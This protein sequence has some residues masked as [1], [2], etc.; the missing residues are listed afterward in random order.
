[1]HLNIPTVLRFFIRQRKPAAPMMKKFRMD[2]PFEG[3]SWPVRLRSHRS[4]IEPSRSGLVGQFPNEDGRWRRLLNY[5]LNCIQ[6]VD[7][8]ILAVLDEVKALGMLENTIIVRTA[9][10]G[11]LA[12]GH[13]MHGKG[14]TAYREQN[15]VPMHIVHP[16]VKGGRSCQALT[17]HIDIVPT[18]LSMAGG[19]EIKKADLLATLKGKDFSKL[20]SNPLGAGVNE[21]REAILYNFNMLVYEDPDFTL[22]VVKILTRKGKEEG[23]KEIRRQGLQ[24]DFNKHRGAIRSVFDGRYKFNRYFSTLQNNQPLTFEELHAVNDVELFDHKNDPHEMVNL[25]ADKTKNK[26]RILEMNTKMNTI[27]REE[28]GVDDESSVGLKQDTDYAF[29]RVDI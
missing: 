16:D 22:G 3:H 20:L 13:G 29:S 17:S 4:I 12:G 21:L 8:H 25:A 28:V 27:V 5:Y 7:R 9:D 2:R 10:H 24:P 1:M 11:E 6:D 26:K 15:H 19:D 23:P 18:I 14:T